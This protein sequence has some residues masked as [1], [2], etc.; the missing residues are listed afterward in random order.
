M[1]ARISFPLIVIAVFTSP[2]W[3][4]IRDSEKSS[5]I[6][7]FNVPVLDASN[8]EL[9][10]TFPSQ[11]QAVIGGITSKPEMEHPLEGKSRATLLKA[12]NLLAKGESEKAITL[13]QK[14]TMDRATAPYAFGILGTNYLKAGD[15]KRAISALDDAVAMSPGIAAYH[16]NLAWALGSDQRYEE[17]LKEARKAIQLDPGHSRYRF[18]IGQILL[19][20]GRKEEAEFHLKKAAVDFPRARALLTTYFGD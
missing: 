9:S 11:E 13:L 15:L 3:G 2:G 6:S 16:S 12:Q 8:H 17:A 7:R 14:L 19:R 4:Q 18:V 10:Y 5:A 20:L 1:L